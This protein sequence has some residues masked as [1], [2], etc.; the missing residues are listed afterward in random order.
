MQPIISLEIAKQGFTGK[1]RDQQGLLDGKV[2]KDSYFRPGTGQR[3]IAVYHRFLPGRAFCQAE[4]ICRVLPVERTH[5]YFAGFML[6]RSI[7]LHFF[8]SIC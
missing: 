6:H 3:P 1:A 7:S 2:Q 4:I 5:R 8:L